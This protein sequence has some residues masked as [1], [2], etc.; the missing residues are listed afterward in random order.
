[1]AHS[2]PTLGPP[3]FRLKTFQADSC[4]L[5]PR[6]H[7]QLPDPT[8]Y[9]LAPPQPER[10]LGCPSRGCRQ[11]G[12]RAGE[13]GEQ[14]ALGTRAFHHTRAPYCPSPCGVS[15]CIPLCSDQ[16][17]EHVTGEGHALSAQ[18]PL[19]VSEVAV[20]MWS[21]CGS[22]VCVCCAIVSVHAHASAFCMSQAL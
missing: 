1:M 18:R 6:S 9:S 2:V 4:D 20:R 7:P 19:F 3:L 8:R 12:Q 5:S 15:Q 22:C 17:Q 14:C 11:H 16:Q 10:P 13:G 21:I